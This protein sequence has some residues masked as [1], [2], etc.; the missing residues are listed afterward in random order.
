MSDG[1][2]PI[3]WTF[4]DE[5]DI[6][7]CPSFDSYADIDAVLNDGSIS[8]YC[9]NTYLIQGMKGTLSESLTT[10]NNYMA[11]GVSAFL[12]QYK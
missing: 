10:Y 7:D 5:P 1:D 3:P 12:T 8:E 2:A 6:P 9:V 4:P 11:N